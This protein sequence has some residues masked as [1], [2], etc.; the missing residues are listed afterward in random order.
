MAL[1]TFPCVGVMTEEHD[2]DCAGRC[3]LSGPEPSLSSRK[4]LRGTS[5]LLQPCGGVLS[6]PFAGGSDEGLWGLTVE[7]RLEEALILA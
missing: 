7:I 1:K 6:S 5:R 2:E 4:L 3:V